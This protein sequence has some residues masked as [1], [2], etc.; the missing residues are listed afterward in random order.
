MCFRVAALAWGFTLVSHEAGL[1]GVHFSAQ[2]SETNKQNRFPHLQKLV[3]L[4][5]QG[6]ET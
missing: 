4:K 6:F 5:Q 1:T 3:K 2:K